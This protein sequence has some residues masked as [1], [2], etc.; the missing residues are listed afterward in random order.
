MVKEKIFK[1]LFARWAMKKE[2]VLLFLVL[3]V[4]LFSINFA[5]ADDEEFMTNWNGTCGDFDC[6]EVEIMDPGITPDSS[7]YFIDKFFDRFGNDIENREERVA[8]IKAMIQTGDYESAHEALRKYNE[9]AEVLEK[10]SDPEKK[11]EARRSAAAIKNALDGIRSNIPEERQEDFYEGI[12]GM[13]RGILAAV[14]ISSKIKEL[15]VQLAELDPVQYATTCRGGG[16][17]PKWKKNLDRDLTEEQRTEAKKFG[18]IMSTCFKTSGQDCN[19]E[20]ISFYDFSLACSKAAPLATACD[21]KGDETACDELDNLEMPELP[22]Y[23]QDVLDEIEGRYSEDKYNMYMPL[24]CVEEGITDPKECGKIMIKTHA[25]LECRAALLEA[26]VDSEREGREI[27]DKIMFKLNAPKECID[28][29]LTDHEECKNFMDSFRGD[30]GPGEFGAPGQN[31]MP[32][33]D[34]MER[35]KCFE[36]A[37]GEVGEHYGV[38]ER[39]EDGKGEITWQCKEN[40]IHWGP[41]CETFMRE[42]WPEQERMKMEEGNIRRAEEGDWRVKEREC[43]ASCDL[44]NGWWDFRDGEC[45][46]KTDE[47]S[48]EPRPGEFRSDSYQREDYSSSGSYGGDGA[49]CGDGYE[50]DGQG[51]CIPFGTG[52]YGF[53]NNGPQYAEGEGPGEPGDY[54]NNGEPPSDGTTVSSDS[55]LSSD[56]SAPSGSEPAP[57]TGEIVKCDRYSHSRGWC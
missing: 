1:C 32:I 2:G 50:S 8:E 55:G 23:L 48:N 17:D 27:C 35:L 26:N 34:P 19:C 10:E 45:I 49:S 7:F 39:F 5:V 6:D 24:E 28:K 25:P 22:D 31:C 20:D 21:I 37:V 38:G 44:V 42:E 16:D 43:S 14:E 54:Y 41:D 51:G 18:K 12:I 53:E 36:S 15:C 56:A 46:C 13:E 33:E 4:F 47:R 40:R 3:S 52:N 30:K 9:Y 57:V 11:G 29:G